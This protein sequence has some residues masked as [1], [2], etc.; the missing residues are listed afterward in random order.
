MTIL[1]LDKGIGGCRKSHPRTRLR[2][3]VIHDR[4]DD[5]EVDRRHNSKAKVVHSATASC[6]RAGKLGRRIGVGGEIR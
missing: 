3:S 1:S 4:D 2:S 6:A 5:F